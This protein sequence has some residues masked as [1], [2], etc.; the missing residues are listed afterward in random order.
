[1]NEQAILDEQKEIL[2]FSRSMFG[3]CILLYLGICAGLWVHSL[4]LVLVAVYT[5]LTAVFGKTESLYYHLFFSLPFTMIYKLSPASTSLFAYVMLLSGGIMLFRMRSFGTEQLILIALF[6][7]YVIPGMGSNVTTVLKILMLLILFYYFVQNIKPQEYKNQIMSFSLG[8]I[9]SSVIGTL[10]TT[11]P[12][13]EAYFSDMKTIYVGAEESNRFTGLYLDPN[14]YSISV[15]LAIFL[16]LLLFRRKDANR[17]LLGVLIVAL[18]VFGFMTYS[19]MYLLVFSLLVVTLLLSNIKSPKQLIITLCLLGIFGTLFYR[20][21][22]STEYFST[23]TRRLESGDISTG[24][25]ELWTDY[26]G[27]IGSSPLTLLL[28]DGFGAGYR[29]LGGPHNTYIESIYV[30]GILGS[31]IFI[32]TILSIFNSKR[33]LEHRVLLNHALPFLFFIMIAVLGCL[34]MND[35]ILHCMLLWMGLNMDLNPRRQT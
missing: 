3:Q 18:V 15:L 30:L 11:W 26:L 19:K 25:F 17:G 29:P 16:C 13:L 12:R 2:G 31:L 20:W 35:L 33:Y 7:V 21:G 28:G 5:L 22:E 32:I 8:M 14:Y 10:K 6:A 34:T 4:F 27:Y 9:G 1:M 24:R 23:M